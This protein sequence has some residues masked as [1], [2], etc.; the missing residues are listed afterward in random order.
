MKDESPAIQVSL[1]PLLLRAE[2]H[3]EDPLTFKQKNYLKSGVAATHRDPVAQSCNA[4]DDSSAVSCKKHC[5]DSPVHPSPQGVQLP[6]ADR[7][8]EIKDDGTGE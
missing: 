8:R 1:S 7:R 4:H 5:S 6:T 3:Q 2:F